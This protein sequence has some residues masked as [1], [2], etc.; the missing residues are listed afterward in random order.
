MIHLFNLTEKFENIP[1]IINSIY[2]KKH[3]ALFR[4]D[5]EYLTTILLFEADFVF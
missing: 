3:V 4:V 1:K 5:F 2:Y